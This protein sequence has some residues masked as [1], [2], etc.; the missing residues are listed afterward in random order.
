M[1]KKERSHLKVSVH[2]SVSWLCVTSCL[3]C[4][5]SSSLPFLQ[6][7]ANQTQ[8]D[9]KLNTRWLCFRQMGKAK[10]HREVNSWI[11]GW[12]SDGVAMCIFVE[13]ECQVKTLSENI[14][15]F[16]EE[17]LSQVTYGNYEDTEVQGQDSGHSTLSKYLF[18]TGSWK[19]YAECWVP[20]LDTST[21]IS[22][23][24]QR[25]R[26]VVQLREGPGI[27]SRKQ[28]LVKWSCE[29]HKQTCVQISFT[30]INE[31][32]SISKPWLFCL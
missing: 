17:Y 32:L 23:L 2:L 11:L 8:C 31:M 19:W 25:V 9:Q 4:L 29:C 22:W 5:Q 27:Y 1:N 13:R 21:V 28:C 7:E 15:L 10:H 18:G 3:M 6:T 12:G 14:W 20:I 24:H 16:T 30:Y 26:R